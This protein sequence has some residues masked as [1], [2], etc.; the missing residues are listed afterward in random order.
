MRTRPLDADGGGILSSAEFWAPF[1][2][3]DL[4]RVSSVQFGGVFEIPNMVDIAGFD[5][6]AVHE[7][8]H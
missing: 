1:L 6:M 7:C 8:D 3:G 4:Q 2:C 5:Q